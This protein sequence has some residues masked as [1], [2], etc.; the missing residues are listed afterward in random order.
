MR[1]GR[2]S[3]SYKTDS[4]GKLLR[5]FKGAMRQFLTA[6]GE[7]GT[8]TPIYY[9]VVSERCSP[10]AEQGQVAQVAVYDVH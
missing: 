6:I 10:F 9:R 5:P 8:L 3:L 4:T 2:L 1:H 7:A